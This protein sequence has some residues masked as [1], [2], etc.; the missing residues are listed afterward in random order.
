MDPEIELLRRWRD[1]DGKAGDQLLL[2]YHTIIWRTVATKVPEAEVEDLVQRVI[3]ALV[4]RRDR[5][6]SDLKFRSYA[7]AVARKMILG[8]FR[9]RYRKPVDHVGVADTSVKD[10]GAGASSIVLAREQDRLL[11]EALRSLSLDDQLVLELYYWEGMTGAELGAVFDCLEPT[12]R[13]RLHRAKGRLELELVEL[14]KQHRELAETMTDLDAWAA[15]VR[16]ALQPQ[17]QGK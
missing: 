4:E 17:L 12:V 9:E 16:E 8:H 5:I 11:L 3:L 2:R 6:S 7:L 13:G 1:G 10:L 14:S 15:S